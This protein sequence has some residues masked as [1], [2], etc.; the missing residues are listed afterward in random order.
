MLTRPNPTIRLKIYHITAARTTIFLGTRF[1]RRMV[2]VIINNAKSAKN[3]HCL[4]QF[5]NPAPILVM[6]HFYLNELIEVIMVFQISI[7]IDTH[8]EHS[9]LIR[10]H[11]AVL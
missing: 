3:T 2:R 10:V 8:R 1:M 9:Y 5:L 7:A 11:S 4:V 6:Q